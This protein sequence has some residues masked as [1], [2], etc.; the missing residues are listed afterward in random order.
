RSDKEKAAR[1]DGTASCCRPWA[2]PS[3]SKVG[4][5]HTFPGAAMQCEAREEHVPLSNRASH[6]VVARQQHR[7]CCRPG[8]RPHWLI[9]A[10]AAL[11]AVMSGPTDATQCEALLGKTFGDAVVFEVADV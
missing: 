5:R 8:S 1:G 7:D 2:K 3:E 4:P 11:G 10:V 6:S 9:P